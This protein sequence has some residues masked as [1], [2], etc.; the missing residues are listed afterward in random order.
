MRGSFGFA[1]FFDLKV[2]HNA[3]KV[4]LVTILDLRRFQEWHAVQ[5]R[6]VTGAT[7]RNE[8]SVTAPLYQHMIARETAVDNREIT[9]RMAAHREFGRIHVYEPFFAVDVGEF[10]ME[11]GHGLSSLLS[12]YP[13]INGL[14]E[15]KPKDNQRE[16]CDN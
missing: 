12:T 7:V 2:Q 15:Q 3:A 11:A 13:K 4:R 10:N 9:R 6:A 5:F 16:K 8:I 1:L 14:E